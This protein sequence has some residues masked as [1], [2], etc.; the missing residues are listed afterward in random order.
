MEKITE[1]TL[2]GPGW[3]YFGEVA[4]HSKIS[5][6]KFHIF[7]TELAD[8]VTIS[9]ALIPV[10]MKYG[11]AMKVATPSVFKAGIGIQEDI[12]YGKCATIYIPSSIFKTGL[13]AHL[14]QDIKEALKDYTK[15]GEIYGD[16]SLDGKI[17]YRYELGRPIDPT[18]GIT[19][20]QY[21]Y[22]YESNRGEYNI[23]GNTD[24]FE[25]L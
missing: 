10:L 17:H 9:N 25:S 8:S 11:M 2:K 15:T 7:G 22:L 23:V 6:W 5:G 1:D 19:Y 13:Q 14:I 4:F 18:V 12:Q 24:P 20:S 16:K 3:K 21:Q